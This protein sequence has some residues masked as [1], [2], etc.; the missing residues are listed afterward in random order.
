MPHKKD[1]LHVPSGGSG[2]SDAA[3][4][5]AQKTTD[6]ESLSYWLV[7]V[8]RAQWPS[9]CPEYLRDVS[10]KNIR[11]LSTLDALYCRQDW[12][13]VERIV[14]ASIVYLPLGLAARLGLLITKL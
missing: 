1:D 3:S 8:P 12:E 13:T 11:V 7:N 6:S 2:P 5:I 10:L 4:T 9:E 14:G